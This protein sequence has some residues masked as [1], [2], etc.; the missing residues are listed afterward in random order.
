MAFGLICRIGH[1]GQFFGDLVARAVRIGPVETDARS[2]ILQLLG[3]EQG[4]QR[5]RDARERAAGACGGAF[6][7]L[8][9]FPLPANIVG[10]AVAEDVRMAAFHLVADRLGDIVE[11]EQAI[12]GRYLAMEYDLEQQIAKLIADR[13]GVAAGDRSSAEQTSELQSLMRTPSS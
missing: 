3:A 1:L 10:L 12:V 4:G 9:R 6:V 2:P 8:D 13:S 11:P 7:C 5:Q